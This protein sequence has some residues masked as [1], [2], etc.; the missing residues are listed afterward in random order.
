MIVLRATLTGAGRG[1]ALLAIA[2][3]VSLAWHVRL[4]RRAMASRVWPTVPGRIRSAELREGTGRD[5][6]HEHAWITYTYT[7]YARKLTGW[8]VRFG[9]WGDDNQAAAE[10]YHI[11][12]S[13]RDVT[14][15]YN[16]DDPE[17]SVLEP[18]PVPSLWLGLAVSVGVVAFACW[19]ILSH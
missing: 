14:V 3:V 8:R 10:D 4:L 15:Y 7:V 13:Q 12:G 2:G 17:Q 9:W 1:H 18:G 5:I 19:W 11:Y 6:G 16:P